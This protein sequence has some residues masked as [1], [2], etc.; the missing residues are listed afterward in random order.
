VRG[1]NVSVDVCAED[2]TLFCFSCPNWWFFGDVCFG[3]FGAFGGLISPVR[4][5]II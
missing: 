1:L 4:R 2:S 5:G 3:I